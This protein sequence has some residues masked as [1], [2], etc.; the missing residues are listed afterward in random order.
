MP[1]LDNVP[2]EVD[3]D[4]SFESAQVEV[5]LLHLQENGSNKREFE[6]VDGVNKVLRVYSFHFVHLS[7]L[8]EL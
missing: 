2:G 4:I 7:A 8:E 1:G 6:D 3:G 5:I